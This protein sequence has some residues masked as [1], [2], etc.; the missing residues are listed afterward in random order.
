M[1]AAA[2]VEEDCESLSGRQWWSVAL[3]AE[4]HMVASVAVAMV[5]LAQW[6]SVVSEAVAVHE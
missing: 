3:V 1:V 5:L 2:H 4:I 6:V